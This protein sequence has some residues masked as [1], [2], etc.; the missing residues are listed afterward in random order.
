M[1]RV[2]VANLS[3]GML[4]VRNSIARFTRSKNHLIKQASY[5]LAPMMVRSTSRKTTEIVG[6]TLH[7]PTFRRVAAWHGSTFH[8]TGKAQH[9]TRYTGIYSATTHPISI[10][11]MTT[12]RLGPALQL[13]ITEFQQTGR[14]GSCGKIRTAR[15][16]FM[17]VRSSASSSR[18]TMEATGNRSI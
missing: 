4:R 10:G 18:S 16:Y 13:V 15:D 3:Q 11:P 17:L 8:R 14:R 6:R 9:T 5:G 1:L 2:R 7:R 12:V